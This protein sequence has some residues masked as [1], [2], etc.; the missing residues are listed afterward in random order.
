MKLDRLLFMFLILGAFLI[1]YNSSIYVIGENEQVVITQFGRIINTHTEPGTYYKIPR[2]HQTHYYKK[3]VY[4]TESS[5]QVLTL[6]KKPLSLT[7]QSSWKISDPA[8]FLTRIR[9]KAVAEVRVEDEIKSA[10]KAALGSFRLDEPVKD[11]KRANFYNLKTKTEI[12]KN[13]LKFAKPK[14]QEIGV[15]LIRIELL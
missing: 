1:L 11:T 10:I 4:R 13:V 3:D 7:V 12:E 15:E 8:L 6:E 2:V 9:D 14:L 5:H